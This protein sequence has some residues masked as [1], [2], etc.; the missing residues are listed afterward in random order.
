[1][2]HLSIQIKYEEQ[3]I[4]KIFNAKDAE[5]VIIQS[6]RSFPGAVEVGGI[7]IG[8]GAEGREKLNTFTLPEP[9]LTIA[10]ED[11]DLAKFGPGAIVGYPAVKNK[12]ILGMLLVSMQKIGDQRIGGYGNE[13][14]VPLKDLILLDRPLAEFLS[15]KD[16]AELFK[17]RDPKTV[18]NEEFK[19]IILQHEKTQPTLLFNPK[20]D[21]NGLPTEAD[22]AHVM[23][24]PFAYQ[25]LVAKRFY[26]PSIGYLL[27]NLE[28][29]CCDDGIEGGERWMGVVHNHLKYTPEEITS[30][31][32]FEAHYRKMV[33]KVGENYEQWPTP[34]DLIYLMEAHDKNDRKGW[35]NRGKTYNTSQIIMGVVLL[36]PISKQKLAARYFDTAKVPEE[37]YREFQSLI[38]Q[39]DQALR[40]REDYDVIAQYFNEVKKYCVD[41][42]TDIDI[43]SAS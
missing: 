21:Q 27:N 40:N 37:R 12:E 22:T 4:G 2:G 19:Q 42:L 9:I 3:G 20:L 14:F 7:L 24:K 32:D 13:M 34:S 1:M 23:L 31:K 43:V 29:N 10:S 18:S 26:R 39:A 35:E 28:E 5:E 17:G 25:T 16:K 8:R 36:H 41:K 15:K 11:M 33:K 30:D 38:R 6:F